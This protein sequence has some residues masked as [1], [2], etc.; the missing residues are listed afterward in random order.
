MTDEREIPGRPQA[1]AQREPLAS[2]TRGLRAQVVVTSVL[3]VV[4]SAVLLA[5]APAAFADGDPG[6]DVL[7]NQDLFLA[8]DAGVSIH[9]Q[10]QIDDL[11]NAAHQ[12]GFP[13]RVAV[14]AQP[15]D[16]G[17]VTPLW[18]K[19]AAYAE[20]L[21]IELSLAYRQRLL[22]V[23]PNGFGFNWP[24][25]SNQAADQLLSAV[26]V[27]PGGSGLAQAT[28]TAV[29]Q[30]AT[31][32]GVNLATTQVGG[33]KEGG[34]GAARTPAHVARSAASSGFN[35]AA[36]LGAMAVLAAVT[37]AVWFVLGGRL[38]VDLHGLRGPLTNLR[39]R[40]R[41]LLSR[42]RPGTPGFAVGLTMSAVV[43]FG[44]FYFTVAHAAPSQA[45]GQ[46][47]ARNPSLGPGQS[48]S[49]PAPDFRLT[50][51]FGQSVSLGQYRGKVVLLA[52]ND[53]ECTSIC[54][55]TTSAMAQAKSL[56]GAAGSQVQL[57]GVDANPKAIS[58]ADV[59][60]YSAVHGLLGSWRFLTGS[61]SQL[62]RVWAEYGVAAEVQQGLISHT[63][64]L[65]VIGPDGR[66]RI[67]FLTQQSYAAVGQLGQLLAQDASALLPDHPP[68]NS[69]LSYTYIPAISPTS[70]VHL[71]RVGGRTAELGPGAPR[72]VLFFATWNKED[73][74]LAGQ[75]DQLDSYEASAH[76]EGL[77]ALTA[78]DEA[79]TEPSATALH[80]FLSQ[81][82]SSL[83]YPV[84]I[85]KSG[86]VGDG[87]IINGT[88]SEGMPW[89]V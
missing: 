87:Y 49:R 14:I 45:V 10:V 18:E 1:K 81:L 86:R 9:Q 54:P 76:E 13:I 7:V 85:D 66:E 11:L 73:T 17:A 39:T 2:V 28:E 63:P 89:F 19:P 24:G 4:F 88:G 59:L 84:A 69:H 12:S 38:R 30:L 40:A 57:L 75:L 6:S 29:R 60:S 82:P 20:F 31:A 62:Q 21:G 44:A 41:S 68:V 53:S 32:A 23:M 64:A 47:L 37:L 52:F 8:A 22:V 67:L 50:D 27:G 56:L 71:P 61:L 65:Y 42:L 78:V 48:M 25:H 5:S 79:T 33:P 74:S 26:S 46:A 80:A 15:D 70:V 55:L 3:V 77:P 35:P 16:L 72:L 51:Q 58:I 43:T 36:L 34:E 83:D